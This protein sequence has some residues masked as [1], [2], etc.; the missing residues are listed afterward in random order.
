MENK[1]MTKYIHN[2]VVFDLSDPNLDNKI[3][4]IEER[5]IEK[6]NTDIE[7]EIAGYEAT[8]SKLQSDISDLQGRLTV[9]EESTVPELRGLIEELSNRISELEGNQ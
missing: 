6:I 7:N 9:I 5:L 3:S 2:G 4:A 8:I 1:R